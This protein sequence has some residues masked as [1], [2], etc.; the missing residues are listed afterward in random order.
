MSKKR[1][2]LYFFKDI[3][4]LFMRNRERE[5]EAETQ[6]ERKGSGR[7]ADMQEERVSKKVGNATEETSLSV[8]RICNVQ[9]G[10]LK[11]QLN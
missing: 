3:I 9:R 2:Y 5:R 10:G 6:A 8:A 1:T 4:Y 7:R 11:S